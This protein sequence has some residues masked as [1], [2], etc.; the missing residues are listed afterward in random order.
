M[1]QSPSWEGNGHPVNQKIPCLFIEAEGSLLWSQD[2]ATGSCR[3]YSP[4]L[5]IFFLKISSN[6]IFPST[7]WS[8]ECPAHLIFHELITLIMTNRLLNALY[9]VLADGKL[10]R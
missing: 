10:C 1:E 5:S 9:N 6:T 3:E 8:S 7:P 2:P 4:H